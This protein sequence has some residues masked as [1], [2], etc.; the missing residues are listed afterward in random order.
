VD[1]EL[2]ASLSYKLSQQHQPYWVMHTG[3]IC[4]PFKTREILLS[5]SFVFLQEP[6]DHFRQQ[7]KPLS[8]HTTLRQPLQPQLLQLIQHPSMLLLLILLLL[9][10]MP[11]AGK[12]VLSCPVQ[13]NTGHA[14]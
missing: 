12:L 13:A 6:Q 11:L 2:P 7:A 5:S 4:S 1:G 10:V 14:S 3:R 9:L 8:L